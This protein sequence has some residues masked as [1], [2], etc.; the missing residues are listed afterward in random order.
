MF[1]V[2]EALGK[3]NSKCKTLSPGLGK[4]WWAVNRCNVERVLEDVLCCCSTVN[5]TIKPLIFHQTEDLCL[6][7]YYILSFWA[8]KIVS[9]RK[10][11]WVETREYP[12]HLHIRLLCVRKFLKHRLTAPAVEFFTPWTAHWLR[13]GSLP[14]RALLWSNKLLIW[15]LELVQYLFIRT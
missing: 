11:P 1:H 9:F 10:V 14:E 4:L 2:I 8:E 7:V 12:N 6:V 5:P 13:H 3:K 15:I